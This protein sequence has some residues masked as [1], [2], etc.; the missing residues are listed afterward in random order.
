M[1]TNSSGTRAPKSCR[2]AELLSVPIEATVLYLAFPRDVNLQVISL[3]SGTKYS[4]ILSQFAIKAMA[5]LLI[6][7]VKNLYASVHLHVLQIVENNVE[8]HK[9]IVCSS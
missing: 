9:E 8:R 7:P 5:T 6:L 2:P 4:I 3:S 1:T